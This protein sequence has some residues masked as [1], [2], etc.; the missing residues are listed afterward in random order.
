MPNG[1]AWMPIGAIRPPAVSRVGF[2]SSAPKQAA[3]VPAVYNP[4]KDNPSSL[5]EPRNMGSWNTQ[6]AFAVSEAAEASLKRGGV[7]SGKATPASAGQVSPLH[8]IQ[9]V[10]YTNTFYA[11]TKKP[12]SEYGPYMLGASEFQAGAA[13][14]HWLGAQ[15][16]AKYPYPANQSKAPAVL[17]S[18]QLKSSAF[19]LRNL[20]DFEGYMTYDSGWAY[21]N[22]DL[23]AAIYEKGPAVT[24]V[25]GS[26]RSDPAYFNSATNSFYCN[27]WPYESGEEPDHLGLI[28][29]WDDNYPQSNFMIQPP[30]PGA[31]LVKD[32]QKV[33]AT[34]FWLSYWDQLTDPPM[35]FDM[36]SANTTANHQSPYEWT[37]VYAH[38]DLGV[39]GGLILQGNAPE[40]TAAN[41]FTAK[42]D[43]T[44]RAVQ[45]GAYWYDTPYKISIYAGNIKAGSPVDGGKAQVITASGAT[46]ISG[47]MA[48]QGYYT[49]PLER[50]VV[51]KKGQ[52]FSI[53]VSY[54]RQQDAAEAN[55]PCE[56]SYYRGDGEDKV[57]INEGESYI[58]NI[59]HKWMDLLLYL[60]FSQMSEWVGNPVIIGLTS[61]TPKYKLT[62][63]ATGGTVA[64][65]NKMVTY[66]SK[67]GA[68]P[69]AKRAGYSFL[70]WY[71]AAAGG[72]KYA[73]TRTV[74][75]TAD[76]TI[77]AHWKA[78]KYVTT[79]KS[80]GGSTPKSG[81]KTMKSK[82][83]TFGQGYGKLPT[84]TR[85]GY[86]FAGWFTSKTGGTLVT[87]STLV[88]KA[89]K[90]SLYAHWIRQ[91]ARRK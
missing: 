36:V 9:S 29:G 51:L 80:N 56:A 73:K 6:W 38:D 18:S 10:F 67:I 8:L 15:T 81:K 20:W 89:G 87:A 14:S 61:P 70:G 41:K 13:L 77:F 27:L 47:T 75:F 71:S 30:T 49:I 25:P 48:Q 65:S 33:P 21:P 85:K 5:P 46:S 3:N 35:I 40:A 1:A 11:N 84:T 63:D 76:T 23:K 69:T 55:I 66:G 83:V 28:I 79:F 88:T 60:K 45:L 37:G 91:P 7:L 86:I 72:F 50:P 43:T 17:S 16:E 26:Q 12:L 52:K 62:Y 82:T 64:P 24:L 22:T 54:Y 74:S 57:T 19:H 34:Y 39:G 68:L 2:N 59:D 53:V 44:L 31:Y 42:E 90:V 58:I 32:N 4:L 78:K